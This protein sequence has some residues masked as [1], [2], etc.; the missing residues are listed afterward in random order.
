MKSVIVV[1]IEADHVANTFFSSW[2]YFRLTKSGHFSK[3]ILH[4]YRNAF[5][6]VKHIST[7]EKFDQIP[8]ENACDIHERI[9]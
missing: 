8:G 7:G 2:K 4:L 3:S 5:K 6:L 1:E 9:S